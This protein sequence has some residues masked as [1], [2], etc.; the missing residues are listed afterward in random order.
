M[1]VSK[2]ITRLEDDLDGSD[3]VETVKFSV[4]GVDYEIDL[5]ESNADKFRNSIG[6]YISHGRKVGGSR[7]G[8]KSASSDGVDIK[9]V[10]KW[11]SSNGIEV[12]T[13][14]RIPADV[15]DKYRQAGN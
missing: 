7:R 1:M 2:V 10:R 5:S 11:A 4:D 14:G 9:A 12:S 3:A 6:D 15:I 13:R 8:R